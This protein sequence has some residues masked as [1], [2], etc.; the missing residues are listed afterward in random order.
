MFCNQQK[1]G[2]HERR[3]QPL[4]KLTGYSIFQAFIFFMAFMFIRFLQIRPLHRIFPVSGKAM[5]PCT[6]AAKWGG[7]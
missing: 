2:Q 6:L 1:I 3:L 4:C 5:N 7:H